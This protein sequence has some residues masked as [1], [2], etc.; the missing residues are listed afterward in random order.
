[1]DFL[2]GFRAECDPIAFPADTQVD[3]LPAADSA[4]NIVCNV[5]PLTV[6]AA[7]APRID[8]QYNLSTLL[9]DPLPGL[10]VLTGMTLIGADRRAVSASRFSWVSAA[11]GTIFLVRSSGLERLSADIAKLLH[12]KHLLLRVPFSF[13]LP[14]RDPDSQD[15]VPYLAFIFKSSQYIALL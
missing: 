4:A 9:T 2:T 5:L 13:S 14:E 1:M 8:G 15:I 12:N 11:V 10:I 3:E 7:K 6:L